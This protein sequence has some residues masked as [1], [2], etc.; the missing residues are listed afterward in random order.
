MK[1]EID[2]EVVSDDENSSPVALSNI[3]F[4]ASPNDEQ[5]PLGSYPTPEDVEIRNF[6][7][8]SWNFSIPYTV[9]I[10]L[11][12]ASSVYDNNIASFGP[13]LALTKSLD[14]NSGFWNSA[15]GD[16]NPWIEFK[17]SD[18]NEVYSVEVVDRIADLY[19]NRFE[20]V[21]VRVG[22]SSGYESA[23]SCG[24]KSCCSEDFT[25]TYTCPENTVG[26]HIFIKKL[27]TQDIELQVN[28][29]T[30]KVW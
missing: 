2:G 12:Q 7:V 28:L 15:A 6:H 22:S 16:T 18:T 30:V 20:Q 9:A 8:K 17:M 23:T 11:V 21:D 25:Y 24:I 5:Y 29:V 13:E 27:G 10:T 14:L 26:Q 1:F 19:K 4:Y 3:S